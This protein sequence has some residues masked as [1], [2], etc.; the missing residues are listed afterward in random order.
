MEALDDLM[1]KLRIDNHL[2]S[3]NMSSCGLTARGIFALLPVLDRR[4][5]SWERMV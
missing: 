1:V 5:R 3:L 4:G 2:S